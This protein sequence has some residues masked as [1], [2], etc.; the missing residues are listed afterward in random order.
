MPSR[1]TVLLV[2]VSGRTGKHALRQLLDRGVRVRAVVRPGTK[3]PPEVAGNPDMKVFE[4]SLL[5]MGDEELRQHL[6]GCDAVISCLGHVPGLKGFFG[7]PR[8]LV[9]RATSLLC[10]GVEE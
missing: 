4:T 6:G 10:R 9:T 7:P 8:D 1:Q 2:G 5:S 3:L